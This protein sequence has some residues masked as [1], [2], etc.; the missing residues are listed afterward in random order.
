[1]I[2]MAMKIMKRVIFPNRSFLND[3]DDK[4]NVIMITRTII[5]MIAR[6]IITMKIMLRITIAMD[7]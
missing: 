5:M 6:F 3:G 1:M 7:I 4:I 2:M